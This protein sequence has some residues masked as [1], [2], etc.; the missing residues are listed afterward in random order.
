MGEN[1]NATKN[2]RERKGNC[3][4]RTTE[5]TLFASFIEDNRL[6]DLPSSGNRFSWYSG[7]EKFMS[8][9]D[10]FLVEDSLIDRWGIVGQRIGLRTISDHCPVWLIINK[11][12]WGPKPFLMNN[13][14]I[15]DKEFLPFV[16]EEWA[17]LKVTGRGE[18]FLKEKLCLLLKS[19]LSGGI[20]KSSVESILIL[21]KVR[22]NLTKQIILFSWPRW[23]K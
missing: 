23:R 7:D 19:L 3:L 10:Q 1:F 21:R 20:R 18:F 22:R 14:W 4:R 11:E 16:E 9:I 17:K 6:I 5:S 13:S 2:S 8:R 12:N 15:E